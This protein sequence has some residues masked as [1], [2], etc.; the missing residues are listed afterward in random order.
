LAHDEL[1]RVAAAGVSVVCRDD[2][3]YPHS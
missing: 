3:T 1:G 2:S